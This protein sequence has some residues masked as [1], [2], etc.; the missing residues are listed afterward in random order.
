MPSPCPGDPSSI[1]CGVTQG[2][3]PGPLTRPTAGPTPAPSVPAPRSG[4]N[5]SNATPVPPRSAP[6]DAATVDS[7]LADASAALRTGSLA[8]LITA[9][10]PAPGLLVRPDLRHFVPPDSASCHPTRWTAA[11]PNGAM[12]P[13]SESGM[14]LSAVAVVLGGVALGLRWAR[15]PSGR[16]A[17]FSAIAG[18]PL[19]WSVSP[20]GP[21]TRPALGRAA[22]SGAAARAV[23]VHGP[24]CPSTGPAAAVPWARLLTIERS[25]AAHSRRL[26]DPWA[27]PAGVR[28][29]AQQASR[30]ARTAADRSDRDAYEN[31]L[32]AEYQFYRSTAGRPDDQSRLMSSVPADA[33]PVVEFDLSIARDELDREEAIR[34]AQARLTR[35]RIVSE[36]QLRSIRSHRPFVV[37]EVAPMT[38]PF[39]P[40]ALD[41]EPPITYNGAFYPHFHT[42]ID[43]AAPLD[44]PVVASADGVVL[45]A[46]RSVDAEGRLVG[47]GNYVM[48]GHRGGFLTVYGHL[49][50]ITVHSGDLVQQGQT[51]GLEGSTGWSTGPHVHFEIR[52]DGRFLDP[53]LF[54]QGQIPDP[55][56]S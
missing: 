2:R 7:A 9:M 41:I 20:H 6:T 46:T 32:E 39:G 35:L 15:R 42:G 22:A 4:A 45:L 18:L 8:R 12:P 56:P 30:L 14:G 34:V 24:G 48:V 52:R 54:V 26:A 38:Q 43:L 44:T 13:L 49:D 55:Q 23:T 33:A 25:L 5:Q 27:V 37:P 51:V 47:Y 11:V 21:V 50:R 29:T 1:L 16:L 31:D 53:A 40:S 3:P 17:L 19:L 10:M 36:A 28:A